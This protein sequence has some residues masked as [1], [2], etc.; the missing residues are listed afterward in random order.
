[1]LIEFIFSFI[2]VVILSGFLNTLYENFNEKSEREIKM[3][4]AIYDFFMF[5]KCLENCSKGEVKIGNY[6]I[7]IKKPSKGLNYEREI[8][9]KE[10]EKT[11]EEFD[12]IPKRDF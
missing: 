11:Y 10:L 5:D 2:V 7:K 12:K 8:E 3:H 4:Q 1:M 9:D 6:K